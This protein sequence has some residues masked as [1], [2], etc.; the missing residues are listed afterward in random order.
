MMA[1]TRS[2]R[3]AH[4]SWG[5][6]DVEI[7]GA[8]RHFKDVKLFPGGAREWDWRETGTDHVPGIQSADVDELLEHGAKV[9]VLSKGQHERLQVSPDTLEFLR[10]KQIPTHVLETR[11]AVRLYNDLREKQPTGGLFHSTC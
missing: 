11:E 1:E 5:Q 9:I 4:L 7:D 2:P 8:V 10:A 6:V 3:I